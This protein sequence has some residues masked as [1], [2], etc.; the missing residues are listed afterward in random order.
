MPTARVHTERLLR[1]YA[2]ELRLPAVRFPTVVQQKTVALDEFLALPNQ[3]LNSEK[4]QAYLVYLLLVR[5]LR[6]ADQKG[7]QAGTFRG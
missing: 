3:D 1:Q 6:L 5:A 7:T 2:P 4:Q